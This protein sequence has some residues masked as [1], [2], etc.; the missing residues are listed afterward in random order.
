ME[1]GNRTRRRL[2]KDKIDF[3]RRPTA[4]YAKDK[5]NIVTSDASTTEMG[6]HYGKNKVT[7]KQN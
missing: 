3:D 2:W 6:S 5:D 4:H 1:M 7:Q